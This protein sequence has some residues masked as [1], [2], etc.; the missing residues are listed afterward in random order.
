M[1][2]HL[3]VKVGA[4]KVGAWLVA[5]FCVLAISAC[6]Q[7]GDL[8]HPEDDSKKRTASAAGIAPGLVV[9]QDSRRVHSLST[10]I[11]RKAV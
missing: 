7:K 6:G 9:I 8:Y 2:K 3:R 1:A 10:S 5:L 4:V 11:H